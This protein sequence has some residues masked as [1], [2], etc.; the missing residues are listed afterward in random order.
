MPETCLTRRH[1]RPLRA[2]FTRP[3]A[4]ALLCTAMLAACGGGGGGGDGGGGGGG[5][6]NTPHTIGGRVDGLT[7]AGL[8]LQNN[9]GN[10]LAVTA[11]GN[12]L[13]TQTVAHGGAYSVT[14]LTQP[15]GQACAVANGSGTANAAVSNIV[16]TCVAPLTLEGSTPAAG[17]TGVERSVAP[18]LGFSA[19]LDVATVAA[20][21]TLTRAGGVAVP[22]TA[23]GSGASVT[24]T[25]QSPL[26]PLATYTVAAATGLR[27]QGGQTL[28]TA[29]S[30]SFTTRDGAWQGEQRVSADDVVATDA[31]FAIDAG[32]YALAVWSQLD[33]TRAHILA[34]RHADDTGWGAPVRIDAD[35]NGSAHKP[36]IAIDANGNALAVWSQS[37][38]TRT[39]VWANRYTAG[40]GWGTAALIETDNGGNASVPQIAIGAGGHAL[41]V[42]MHS[43]GMRDNIWANRYTAGTGWGTAGPIE[44]GD[45]RAADPRIAI[46]GNGNALAVWLQH[47]GTRY[48]IFA[49]RYAEGTGWGTAALIE[50]GNA[51]N[52]S[53][54]QIAIDAS[55]NALAVWAQ[56]D[57]GTRTANIWA[58]RYAAGTG[59]GTAAM[60]E[61]GNIGPAFAP[62]V[63]FDA[64]GSALAVWSKFDGTRTNIW[65]SRYTAGTGWG[66]A[67]LIETDNAGSANKPQIAIDAN[68]NA[69]AVWQQSD[70]EADSVWANRYAAGTGWGTAAL[71]ETDDTGFDLDAQV[72]IDANGNALALWVRQ[73]RN[74]VRSSIR[75][76]RF[77]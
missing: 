17:A 68:G 15:Q 50:T 39:N 18:T 34:S 58:N 56:Y 74:T 52:A 41:A 71:L 2:R 54:P 4:A 9:G 3:G 6:G 23:A 21:V 76:N 51:G 63:A 29:A 5:G 1:A 60:V 16:V 28:G 10:D 53:E 22:A 70:G 42:W 67:A 32:G 62:Q 69:L 25:P 72:A 43:D 59:W 7:G 8:V 31:R 38:G 77:R 19:P 73:P 49:N 61:T 57:G 20:N 11:A 40:T 44:T 47:D 13:F 33:G 64:G 30:V 36:Q 75:V 65:A 55:G 66:A 35:Q 46:D 14:V 45:G 48:S 24:V 37:D 12:F 26:M 27:G